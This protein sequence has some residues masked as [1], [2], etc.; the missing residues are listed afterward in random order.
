MKNFTNPN[1]LKQIASK[2]VLAVTVTN[3]QA[4]E[5]SSALSDLGVPVYVHTVNNLDW[6]AK[7]RKMG[8]SNVYTDTLSNTN[9]GY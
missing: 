4:G 3:S 5:L 6:L 1:F 8:V 9:E 2:K 7:L